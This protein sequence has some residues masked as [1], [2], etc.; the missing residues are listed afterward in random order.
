MSKKPPLLDFE[1]ASRLA[2]IYGCTDDVD[3]S[4]T[5]EKLGDKKK[6]HPLVRKAVGLPPE[7]I[8]AVL[9]VARGEAAMVVLKGVAY[10]VWRREDHFAVRKL[11][12]DYAQHTVALDGS[13]CSCE[14]CVKGGERCK[15]MAAVST[16][17]S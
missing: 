3:R 8:E 7:A 13:S 12:D 1:R 15:H 5:H 16:F 4:T 9:A 14:R 6:L 11:S 2:N 10:A 17:A